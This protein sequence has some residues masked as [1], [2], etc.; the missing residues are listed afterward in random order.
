MSKSFRIRVN[1]KTLN[2]MHAPSDPA[3]RPAEEQ[4]PD[5]TGFS[6]YA[7]TDVGM[8][9]R[10]NQ[11]SLIQA[12]LLAGVADG[13]GG[14]LG[15]ETASAMCRDTLIEALAGKTPDPETLREAVQ[16][17]NAAVHDRSEK[18]E[19]VYGMGTTL[20][21]LW[22]GR[23]KIYLAH[24]GDSRC[25]LFS[26]GTLKQVSDD[27][28]MVMEMVRAGVITVEQAEVHPMRNIITRAIG[29]DAS[30]VPDILEF[31]RTEGDLWLLCSDGLSGMVSDEGIAAVLA[32]DAPDGD[33]ARTLIDEA[34][35]AG[36]HD[37][38]SVVLVR[39]GHREETV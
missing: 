36:G 13:M 18:D 33:K 8:V 7:L 12:G 5:D 28:S 39:I 37:N 10:T 35:A 30:V 9:R 26:G 6:V 17:A 16:R 22:I 14:H 20:C 38:V 29:T 32:S 1:R 2:R 25:Y 21:T 34:L 31:P 27:H 11:D 23:E 15:G 24:V 19:S 4:T 3:P